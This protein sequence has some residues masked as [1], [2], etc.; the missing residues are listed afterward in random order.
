[1]ARLL[2]PV[3]TQPPPSRTRRLI[4]RNRRWPRS[5]VILVLTAI[6]AVI[7]MQLTL[8]SRLASYPRWLLPALQTLV[9]ASPVVA[10]PRRLDH[11]SPLLRPVRLVL[12]AL[13]A[14]A[15]AWV[16][17]WLMGG[18]I[19]GSNALDAGMLLTTGIAVWLVNV[20]MFALLYWDIER[21]RPQLDFLFPQ[22]G[23]PH[24]FP[25]GWNPTF[26]DYL[27]LSYTNATAFSPTDVLPLSRWAKLTMMLQSAISLSTLA[28]IIARAI[29]T[30]T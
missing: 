2:T 18:F 26:T 12:I 9:L 15:N 16:V 20:V 17:G 30:P 24:I 19:L 8:P 13:L 28:L 25:N 5:L 4:P 6:V 14:L 21:G 22:N 23:N 27:Y 3:Q 11:Q 1:V 29:N 7:G 10:S